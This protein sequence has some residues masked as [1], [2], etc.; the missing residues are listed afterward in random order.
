M[1]ILDVIIILCC[2]PLL[3]SGYKKG[4][5]NQALS[6]VA[7]LAGAW[8]ASG[9]GD[10]TGEWIRPMIEGKCSNPQQM[11]HIIGIAITFIAVCILL[12]LVGILIE[13]L[14]MIIIPEWVNKVLG[15]GLAVANSMLLLCTLFLIFQVLNKLFLFTDLKSALFTDSVLFQ[16]IESTSQKLLPNL[17]NIFS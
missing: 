14:L 1:N 10:T 3:I 15:V 16:L 5:V 8:I 7:L 4:F 2:C 13:K 11:S 17:L 12:Y 6:I 9:L